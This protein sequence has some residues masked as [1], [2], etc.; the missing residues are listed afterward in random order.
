MRRTIHKVWGNEFFKGG[1]LITFASF[2]ANILNYFFNVLAARALG[3]AGFGEISALFSYTA[4]FSIPMMV[5][6]LVIINKIGARGNQ[7][8][9]FAL[10]LQEWFQHKLKKWSIVAIPAVLAIPFIPGFTNLTPIS[11]YALIPYIVL[12]FLV[13]FYSSIMQ[14]LQLFVWFSVITILTSTLKLSGALLVVA[15]VDG[16]TTVV[17]FL[18]LSALLPNVAAY[19]ILKKNSRHNKIILEKIDKRLSHALFNRYVIITALSILAITLFNNIDVIFVKKFFTATSAGIYSSWSLFAKIILYFMGPLSLVSFIF[20]SDKN[21]E[22]NHERIL[23]LTLVILLF[24]GIASFLFYRY[25]SLEIIRLLFGN[26]FD[27]VAP[28][29]ASAS[30]FGTFYTTSSFVNNYFLAKKSNFSLML[31]VL[32]PLYFILLFLIP[33]SL[34][35]IISLNIYFSGAIMAVYLV[36]YGWVIFYNGANGKKKG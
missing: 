19:V 29:M 25:L 1:A 24:V 35:S 13:A 14:G 34:G 8:H 10:S 20:F 22:K 7:A 11:G 23:N 17:V 15:G 12:N 9:S 5:M 16:L 2:V 6:S 3:P 21:S 32:I 26:K 28:Y 30:L 33:R 18:I 4:V 27:A 36:A 31:F